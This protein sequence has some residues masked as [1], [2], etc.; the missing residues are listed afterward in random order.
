MADRAGNPVK[1]QAVGRYLW[2]L[3]A[4]LLLLAL[5][6]GTALL[7]LGTLNTVLSLGVSIAKTLLVM[8]IFMHESEARN[9]TRLIS[10]LGFIWLAILIGFTLSDFLTRAPVPPPW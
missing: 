1:V 6:T 2:T 9:L 8:A 3:T 10:A 5:S 7:R 4:L